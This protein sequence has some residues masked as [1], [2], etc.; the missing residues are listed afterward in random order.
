MG[1]FAAGTQ[2]IYGRNTNKSLKQ[3]SL[4]AYYKKT[5]IPKVWV[6]LKEQRAHEGGKKL[7]EIIITKQTPTKL[8]SQ[9]N[10]LLSCIYQYQN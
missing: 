6:C 3:D 1:Y 7:E 8:V 4:P 9:K 2:E 10:F 5:E